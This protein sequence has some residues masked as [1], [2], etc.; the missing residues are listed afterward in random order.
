MIL[1]S[2]DTL[3]CANHRHSVL[4]VR[5]HSGIHCFLH[6]PGRSISTIRSFSTVR[7]LFRQKLVRGVLSHFRSTDVRETGLSLGDDAV[8]I[9]LLGTGAISV[10]LLGLWE[11]VEGKE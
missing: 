6:V 1:V 8:G 7:K 3:D 11:A 5:H 9:A 4:W 2:I 10:R